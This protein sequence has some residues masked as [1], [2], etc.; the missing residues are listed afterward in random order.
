MLL[1]IY[2][3]RGRLLISS[4]HYDN[5][6]V[7]FILFEKHPLIV[8]KLNANMKPKTSL[9]LTHSLYIYIYVFI[10]RVER[11]KQISVVFGARHNRK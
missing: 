4:Q 9:S 8:M 5:Q 6:V 2:F 7:F 10:L 3:R 11:L 1:V